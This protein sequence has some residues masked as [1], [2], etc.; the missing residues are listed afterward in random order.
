[1]SYAPG[2]SYRSQGLKCGGQSHSLVQPLAPHPTGSGRFRGVL[3]PNPFPKRPTHG[4]DQ[5]LFPTT[6]RVVRGKP[7]LFGGPDNVRDYLTKPVISGVLTS[8]GRSQRGLKST[9]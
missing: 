2:M 9:G 5:N 8:R 7:E 6:A 1:M 4:R 3:F